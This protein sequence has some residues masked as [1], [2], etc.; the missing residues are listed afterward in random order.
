MAGTSAQDVTAMDFDPETA[1]SFPEIPSSEPPAEAGQSTE[2]SHE[3][4]PEVWR[5]RGEPLPSAGY[6]SQE[7]AEPEWKRAAPVEG[8]AQPKVGASGPGFE[9]Y[10]EPG[11]REILFTLFRAT[12]DPCC[13][14]RRCLRW[15]S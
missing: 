10:P 13:K 11:W 4:P 5:E 7:R 6:D 2:D 12:A 8:V 3:A 1:T 15:A 14:P 9:L